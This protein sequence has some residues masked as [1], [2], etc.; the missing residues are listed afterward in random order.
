[1]AS[2]EKRA[3]AWRARVLV[4]GKRESQTFRTKGEAVAWATQRETGQADAPLGEHT[5]KQALRRYATDVA[6]SHA[7]ERWE[8]VRC[9]LLER[10]DIA[11]KRLAVLSASDLAA[12]RDSRLKEVAPGSVR[13]E[14]SLLNSVLEVA[15]KEW[16]W[17]RANPLADVSKPT[18]P[19]SRKRR[20]S[21]DEVQRVQLALGYDGGKPENASQRT[22]LAFEFAIETAMRSG[23]ILGLTWA[24]VRA[25]AVTLPNTKNGDQRDVPLSVRAREIIALLP[26][27]AATV[28]DIDAGIRDTLFRKARDRAGIVNLTFH[29]SRA[30]A[31]WRLSKK[32]GVL[33]LARIIG[34]RDIRSLMIYFETSADELADR[35]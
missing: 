27:D 35:L 6:P 33:E 4:E 9:A 8:V 26:R 29:D 22:A 30:E 11:A 28:F 3:G 19:A 13:R 18:A 10:A 12:W 7:G 20:V 1:M 23:E 5:L 14:M 2:Y 24:H 32:L 17:L 21:D 31:I 25:K 16:G 34:H 15:R